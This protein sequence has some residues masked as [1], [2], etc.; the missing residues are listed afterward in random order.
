MRH[1]VTRKSDL[2]VRSLTNLGR[3]D[4]LSLSA[5]LGVG[6]MIAGCGTGSGSDTENVAQSVDVAEPRARVARVP[7]PIDFL[8]TRWRADPFARGSYS[9]LSV[10]ADFSDRGLLGAA[11]DRRFFAGEATDPDY[12]A[13]VHGALISGQRAAAEIIAEG[14]QSVIVI[15][16][17]AAGLAAARSLVDE[18]KDVTVVEARDRIGGR[19]WTDTTLGLPLDL[20]ASWIHG[21]SGNPLTPIADDAAIERVKTR[22]SSYRVRDDAGAVVDLDDL[23]ADFDDV[24]SIEHEYAAPIDDLS[25]RADDE[26]EEFSGGDVVMPNGYIEILEHL[27][28]GLVIELGV[29]VDQVET[30]AQSA[31]VRS[32]DR[33]SKADAVLVTVPLGVLKTDAMTFSPPLDND[34]LGAIDR[35]GMG[36]LDKVY[37]RFDDVFW[38]TDVDLI[39]YVGPNRGYFAEWLNVA[40][41]TGEPILLGFNAAAEADQIELLNDQQIVDEAMRVLRNMYELN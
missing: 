35:L 9:Y 14:H 1:E 12:P 20:G 5:A 37:L 4:F 30:S 25:T 38:D 18:G 15:G 19:V 8:I 34:R 6:G 31:T 21:V 27:T 36:L 16:A 41:F 29:I 40:K 23:P 28:D 26:G 10:D 7:D 13:T 2:A 33:T 32:G 3:R 17:G 22:Y 11:E 24:T 39:G